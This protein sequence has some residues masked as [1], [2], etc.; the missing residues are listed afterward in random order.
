M[1]LRERKLTSSVEK[2]VGEEEASA[3]TVAAKEQILAVETATVGKEAA[4]PVEVEEVETSRIT[5]NTEIP[6]LPAAKEAEASPR[7]PTPDEAIT[8]SGLPADEE[9]GTAPAVTE[10][11]SPKAETSALVSKTGTTNHFSREELLE[12]IGVELVE[13]EAKFGNRRSS[14]HP[15]HFKITVKDSEGAACVGASKDTECPA[16][17][18]TAM[19]KHKAEKKKDSHRIEKTVKETARDSHNFQKTKGVPV[20]TMDTSA[21]PMKNVAPPKDLKNDAPPK[22]LVNRQGEKARRVTE[23]SS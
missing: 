5:I 16:C 12:C 4:V 21:P 1:R 6:R 8:S 17:E 22:V 20:A 15:E 11:A 23:D 10:T 19:N 7:L 3:H 2:S 13:A 18:V 9:V 14:A